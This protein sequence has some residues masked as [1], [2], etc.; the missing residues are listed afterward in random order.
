MAKSF[1][2]SKHAV[3]DAYLAVKAN[4][5]PAGIDGQTMEGFEADV[6]N[7]LY[8]IWNRLLYP[9][10]WVVVR[11]LLSTT[12]ATCRN[13]QGQRKAKAIGDTDHFGS[14]C[15]NGDQESSGTFGGTTL[16]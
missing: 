2:L 13:T 14:S 6:K 16:S 5:G 11:Q 8:K 1:E 7:N 4:K 10:F 15:P 3:W 12:G 9:H